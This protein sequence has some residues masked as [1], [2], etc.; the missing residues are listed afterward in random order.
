[1]ST[2][3]V[4]K[5]DP[6][7]GTDLEIGTSGD[8]ITVPSGA[9]LVVAGTT[10]ITGTNNVQR[11]N[12]QP[13]MVN[14][15]MQVAQ[16]GTSVASLTSSGA[17]Q[18][19]DRIK[20]EIGSIGTYTVTQEA[21]TSGNAYDDG[22]S[23]AWRI[24]CTTADASPAAGDSLYVTYS[25]EGQNLQLFKKGT[26]NAEKFTLAFWIKSKKTGTGQVN[27]RDNDN[28]RL[29]GGTYTIS[30]ADTWEYKVVNFAADTT[31]VFGNDNANS[32]DIEWWLDSGTNYSSGATPTAWE[33]FAQTDRNASGTLAIADSTDN[34]WAI[35]AIQLEVGE[36]TSSTIPSFQH[37]SYGDNLSRCQRY[38]QK[39]TNGESGKG[40][41][42][43]RYWSSTAAGGVFNLPTTMRANPTAAYANGTGYW[44]I[45]GGTGGSN[46][47][48]DVITNNDT[49]LQNAGWYSDSTATGTAG[50]A[51]LMM[52][53]SG[54]A[55]AYF[56]SE[57]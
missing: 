33:A 28:T 55:Q 38:F 45:S 48:F 6:S 50:F 31:G 43:V 15:D 24:D 29:I 42:M 56:S 22:F 19:V 21:L 18:T 51:G 17:V 47:P 46:D 53:N 2:L 1:M 8:T 36:F 14:G 34:D 37:E 57:L 7:T 54:S 44:L 23:M 30:V 13:L 49:S 9:T 32:M 11:P 40:I 12:A 20:N 16:R 52:T 5:V 26:S 3:N 25:F 39:L 35:T 27:L 10:E 41:S 4:D